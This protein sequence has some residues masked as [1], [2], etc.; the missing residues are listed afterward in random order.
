VDPLPFVGMYIMLCSIETRVVK[1][2]VILLRERAAGGLIAAFVGMYNML[3][4]VC[5]SP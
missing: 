5:S 1:R 4:S 2:E 3:C